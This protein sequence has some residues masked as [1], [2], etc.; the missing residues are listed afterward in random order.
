MTFQHVH[1]L[2]FDVVMMRLC[3]AARGDL[4]QNHLEAPAGIPL[5]EADIA[6]AGMA[7]RR[8]GGQVVDMGD[9]IHEFLPAGRLFPALCVA[10]RVETGKTRCHQWLLPKPAAQGTIDTKAGMGLA[11]IYAPVRGL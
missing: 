11:R 8:V 6:R 9:Q 7:R 10:G 5:D 4:A 2:V 1:C 3:D